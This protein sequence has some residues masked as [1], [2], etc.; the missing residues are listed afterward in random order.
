[1]CV[2]TSSLGFRIKQYTRSYSVIFRFSRNWFTVYK[3][4]F[5]YLHVYLCIQLKGDKRLYN[6]LRSA[7]CRC[8][9]CCCCRLAIDDDNNDRDVWSTTITSARGCYFFIHLYN[10]KACILQPSVRGFKRNSL[11][12]L[13]GYENFT[14]GLKQGQKHPLRRS[15]FFRFYYTYKIPLIWCVY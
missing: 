14:N 4:K 15:N 3:Y 1:M 13:T 7:I 11:L 2:Y 5:I 9:C 12:L 10:H 8:C 6:G